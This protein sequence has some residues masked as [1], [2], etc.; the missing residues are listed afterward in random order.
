[1][2]T[3]ITKSLTKKIFLSGIFFVI[4][5]CSIS[6]ILVHHSGKSTAF[7]VSN[8]HIAYEANTIKSNHP[9]VVQEIHV[10]TG[11]R[12][13]QGD[14]LLTVQNVVSE[15]DL[16][17]LQQSVALAQKNLEQVRYGVID[18]VQSVQPQQ[19]SLE[20]ARA[21]MERM[22]E[23]YEMGAVSAVK[24]N[25]AAE[26]Y[27]QERS[28]L[29]NQKTQNR[30]TN[31]K[32]I[33]M[34]EEQLKKAEEALEK[35][36]NNNA[37]TEIR[38][39]QAGTITRVLVRPGDRIENDADMLELSSTT[40]CWV[41]A[42]VSEEEANQIYPGQVVHYD[43]DGIP[44]QGTVEEIADSVSESEDDPVLTEKCIRISVPYERMDGLEGNTHIVVHFF[45]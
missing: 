16:V 37:P 39:Q 21:R 12:V 2:E 19:E 42:T 5:I 31:P 18:S 15:E 26:A 35:A 30:V 28:A 38:A 3:D 29:T 14:L 1:M 44:V 32:A 4:L 8:A 6:F 22:N 10:A 17:R 24:R 43:L 20:A 36:Q 34:A 9:L 33:Q 41:E 11:D 27:E 13:K 40:H 7:T 45:P 23:L 25:E